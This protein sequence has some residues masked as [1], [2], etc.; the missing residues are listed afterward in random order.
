MNDRTFLEAINYLLLPQNM[1]DIPKSLNTFMI[2]RRETTSLDPPKSQGV[3][4]SFRL[5]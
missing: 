4:F 3:Q 1:R 5:F 2:A